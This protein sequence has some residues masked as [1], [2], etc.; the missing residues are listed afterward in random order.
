MYFTICFLFV[1]HEV[2]CFF[3]PYSCLSLWDLFN[4][5]IPPP[6]PRPPQYFLFV[7]GFLQFECD[8]PSCSFIYI[9]IYIYIWCLLSF[10]DLF[11]CLSLSQE[12]SWPLLPQIF[13][14][15]HLLFSFSQFGYM[16]PMLTLSYV[17]WMLCLFHIFSL[18]ILVWEVPMGLSS[19]LMILFDYVK[20][21]VSLL[22]TLFISVTVFFTSMQYFHLII[23]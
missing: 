13:I 1:P 23:S 2:S 20:P 10:L 4:Y 15:L 12:N 11:W 17:S 18:C 5:A 14:S 22:K 9:Y 3:F 19:S 7:S 8:I 21:T 6:P 16:L